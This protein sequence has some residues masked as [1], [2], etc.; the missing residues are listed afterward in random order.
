MA[1][2]GDDAREPPREALDRHVVGRRHDHRAAKVRGVRELVQDRGELG[3]RGGE[4][5]VHD[6]EPLLDRPAEALEQHGP[7]AGVAG[8]EHAHARQLRLGREGPDD[9]RAGGAVTRDVALVVVHDAHLLPVDLDAHRPRHRADERVV[10]LD[11]AV[12]DADARPRPGRPAPG[13]LAGDALRPLGRERELR[14]GGLAAD[15]P[16]G[17]SLR[18]AC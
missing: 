18:H 12:E 17:K 14:R 7:A 4:A 13:P 3:L 10:E 16:G 15:A 5:H 8:A 6:V 2:D 9:P 11:A 1:A